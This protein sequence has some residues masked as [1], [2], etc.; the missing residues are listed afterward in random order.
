MEQKALKNQIVSKF[1]LTKYRKRG[2]WENIYT[3]Q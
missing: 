3:D 2:D 1:H